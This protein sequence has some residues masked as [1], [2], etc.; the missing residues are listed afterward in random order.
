MYLSGAGHEQGQ[1]RGHVLVVAGDVAVRRRVVQVAPSANVAA[2]AMVPGSVLL[3]SDVPCDT[4]CLD[5]ARDPN[6]VLTRL[7][8]AAATR[9]PLLVYLSG[10][11]T[12]D[13]R[14]GGLCF[15]LAGA[16]AGTVRYSA[17][18]WE[19]LG[20]ELRGRPA[21]LT[22]VVVDLVADKSAW[23][24]L[25]ES[26]GLPDS[27]SAEVYGVVCPPAFAPAAVGAAVSGY[28]RHWIEQL[29]RGP[30]RPANVQ[31]HALA[32]SAA[33][34]PPGTLVLPTARELGMRS[35]PQHEPQHPPQAHHPQQPPHTHPSPHLQQSP[36]PEQPQ[37]PAPAPPARGSVSVS[38][39][40]SESGMDWG[41]GEDPR[42]SIHALAVAGRHGEAAGLARVWEEH[43]LQTCGQGSSEAIGWAEIRADLARMAGDF[44]LATRLWMGV[45]QTRLTREGAGGLEV[46][47]AAA[48]ALYCWAQLRDRALVLEFGPDLVAL[49]RVLPLP[50]PRHLRLA[51]QRLDA[52]RTADRPGVLHP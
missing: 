35:G 6:T 51:E 49:L 3:G 11:L 13:R 9:G 7:R 23:P 4:V 10:R 24:L 30:G 34:L 22:T 48:G 32:V 19:W 26:G 46:H 39:S 33:A 42:P 25:Q 29:R 52:L 15:A 2:L 50:D 36:H 43:A 21:G 5:G 47:A 41:G 40:V 17:L 27:G 37:Q 31:V 1:G 28:T 12:V 8:A 45:G 16:T 20:V 44:P 38:V 18:P 14:G